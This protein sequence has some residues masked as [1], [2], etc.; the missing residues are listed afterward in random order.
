MSQLKLNVLVDVDP[1]AGD[2]D[3][4]VRVLLEEFLGRKEGVSPDRVPATSKQVWKLNKLGFKGNA[5]ALSK[6]EASREI[7]R[8]EG[9]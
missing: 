4:P 5:E 6:D 8:L 9:D 2:L 7:S 1:D 3:K